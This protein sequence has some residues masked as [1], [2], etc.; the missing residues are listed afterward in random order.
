MDELE[1]TGQMFRTPVGV[2]LAGGKSRRME[3]QDKPTLVLS[4]QPLFERVADRLKPQVEKLAINAN[5]EAERFGTTY[6]VIPDTVPGQ[7]GPLAGVLAALKWADAQGAAHVVTVPADTPFI[8]PDL[9]ER[10]IKPAAYYGCGVVISHD[11]NGSHP[12]VAIWSTMLDHRLE[13][14]IAAGT[15]R[16]SDFVKTCNSSIVHFQG[17]PFYN[18]NTPDEL[19]TAETILG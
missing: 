7:P 15:R 1:R 11:E 2:V 10:L 8:P 19:K 5:G 17:N 14:A 9:T 6:P 3:G 18:I 16:V 12:L 13:Q 4:G